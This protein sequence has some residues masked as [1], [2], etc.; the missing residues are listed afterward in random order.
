[1]KTRRQ[2]CAAE[3][4]ALHERLATQLSESSLRTQPEVASRIVTLVSERGAG[5]GDFARVLRTDPG[6]SGRLLR[7]A[8]SAFFAPRDPVTTVD[9]ACV[10]LGIERIRAISLGF[11]LSRDADPDA[12]LS[13]RIW[14]QSVF[15]ACL[16]GALGARHPGLN[17]AEAFLTGLML[18]TGIPLMPG[19]VGKRYTELVD[20]VSLPE[21]L[22]R[23]ESANLPFTHVDV[24]AALARRWRLPAM[25]AQPI[26]WHHTVPTATER[27]EPVHRMHRIA[28]FVGSVP[29]G[30]SF[31][32]PAPVE[33]P[34][35]EIAR[36]VDL[37]RLDLG[38]TIRRAT[39]E[40]RATLGIFAD[41]ADEV[42]DLKAVQDRALEH[43][44]GSVEHMI[45]ETGRDEFPIT[46]ELA[47]GTVEIDRDQGASYRAYLR[48]SHGTRICCCDFLAGITQPR[49]ILD[50]LGLD[51]PSQQSI[52][53]LT[54]AIG[55][56]AA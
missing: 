20:R 3:V 36:R 23:L 32:H 15:R 49:Q 13:R 5:V 54:E 9:R 27:P 12:E 24:A 22:H 28:Y 6:L 29:I 26:G 4:D 52:E 31:E 40:Y 35:A 50:S 42:P 30:G 21:E 8:N 46:L 45:L 7:M 33:K 10:L 37:R 38:E 2:L 53:S 1:M 56:L 55:R 47:E 11:Y 41:V 17:Q 34:T 19:L 43:L 51:H 25:L 48:D 44:I 18:D 39:E 16:A 14:G